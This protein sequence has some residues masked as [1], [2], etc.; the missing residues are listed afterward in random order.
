MKR[1]S[2]ILLHISSLPSRYPIGDFG[3]EAY[4][5]VDWLKA[6]GQTF[7]Q[8]LPLLSP[9]ETG[10]PY[11]SHSAMGISSLFISLDDLFAEGLLC[12]RDVSFTVPTK[13][14]DYQQAYI[15]KRNMLKHSYGHY[16]L[17]NNTKLSRDFRKFC[18]QQASWLDEHAFFDALKEEHQGQPWYNW[19][20]QLKKRQPI[21]L[22]KWRIKLRQEII[23]EKYAQW[24]AHRQWLKLKK[25]ANKS[26]V[27]IIGDIPFFVRHDSVDVWAHR[28]KYLLDANGQ[29]KIVAG[30]PPDMYS[31]VGQRWGNPMY[32]WRA[33]KRDK[34]V[35][36]TNRIKYYSSLFDVLRIDHFRGYEALWHIP[37]KDKDA[38]A[39]KWVKTP[40]DDLL[41]AIT[42]AAPADKLIA[43][44]IGFITS[45]VIKLRDKYKI[46]GSRVIQF[47]FGDD[48]R[49][50][51]LPH[52]FPEN[53]VAYTSN[54]DT[55]TTVGWLKS[56]GKNKRRRALLFTKSTL[57][58]F[59]DRIIK[60]GIESRA[61]WFII[62]L[63]DVL[64]LDSKARM[65]KPN[66]QKG[67]WRWRL[68]A[69]M[70]SGARAKKLS[71]LT[72]KSKRF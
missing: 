8:I 29:P 42:I 31:K 57:K 47:G 43:E 13:R 50:P 3:Q 2:G 30:A 67:N 27:R 55:D 53:S 52:N 21:T 36:W 64:K 39:G 61:K 23:Y 17:S 24:I 28:E 11:A 4:Q 7:W 37:A 62:P 15:I 14:V 34:F 70:L 32:N 69:G 38:R 63:Q 58:N 72:K 16:L 22:K 51:S 19:S 66:S 45:K 71:L 9:D 20:P 18:E 49:N 10:S 25:Y 44:D 60:L 1:R 48:L 35:W 56:T 46:P 68:S 5:F 54:H 6:A 12:K 40:G 65:N 33:I 59:T 41:K 26:N